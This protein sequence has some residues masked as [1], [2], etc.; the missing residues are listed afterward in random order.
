MDLDG[1]ALG[2]S[3]AAPPA[4]GPAAEEVVAAVGECAAA[5]LAELPATASGALRPSRTELRE[6][7]EGGWGGVRREGAP[8]ATASAGRRSAVAPAA[9]SASALGRSAAAE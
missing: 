3:A 6:R 4:A 1:A 2:A 5:S 7:R 8:G 9:V